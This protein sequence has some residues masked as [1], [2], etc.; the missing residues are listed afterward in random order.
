MA[1]LVAPATA[2]KPRPRLTPRSRNGRFGSIQIGD[3]QNAFIRFLLSR[4][5]EDSFDERDWQV[6]KTYFENGCAYCEGGG[7]EQ[8]DHGVP[9]NR[10]KL[11]E[12]RLGNVIPACKKCNSGKH[13]RDY[14]EHL[15]DDLERVERI[16]AYMAS[17]G[18][19]PLGD[20]KQVK[21]I[22][23]QAH[24]EVAAV[25]ERYIAMLNDVL[26]GRASPLEVADAPVRERL[27]LPPTLGAR[28]SAAIRSW[29]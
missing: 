27:R 4:L 1:V 24:K 2:P 21:E 18:Y 15:G 16:E 22:L 17:R 25:A 3:A 9:I 5:G 28:L 6:T 14:R 23:E 26:A 13:Q 10:A 8:M 12:H 19:V 20:H 11:G 29:I 7:A